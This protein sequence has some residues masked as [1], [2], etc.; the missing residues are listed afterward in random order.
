MEFA[1]ADPS[2]VKSITQ[3]VLLNGW[4]R[5]LRKP[6]GPCRYC[7]ISAPTALRAVIDRAVPGPQMSAHETADLI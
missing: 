7:V 2:V 5:A 1:S 4:L 3:R 6:N